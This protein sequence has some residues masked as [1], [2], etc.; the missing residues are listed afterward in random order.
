MWRRALGPQLSARVL[1]CT[2]GA[3]GHHCRT[4]QETAAVRFAEQAESAKI[5]RYEFELLKF[6]DG[7]PIPEGG[8]LD[9]PFLAALWKAIREF[10]PDYLFCPPLPT[11]PLMGVHTDHL[12]VA[13][14]VRRVAY[15]INVP[16][17]FSDIYPTDESHSE[18]V[19]TPVIFNVY[20]GYMFG[21]N[22]YDLAVDVEDA[23]PLIAACAYCHRSQF[24]EWIP[25]IGRHEI[26]G[27]T[28]IE[29]WSEALRRRM[30][31]QRQDMRV[32]G[33]R[34]LEFFTATAWGAAP[35]MEGLERDFPSLCRT[36]SR[37]GALGEKLSRW[38]VL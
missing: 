5:G 31:R 38:G 22:Q 4:R 6:P 13:E 14:A 12:T 33:D 28:T 35:T 37:L 24:Q 20:D 19:K 27:P 23:F 11:D 3:A 36:H 32:G 16:H 10:E 2:D 1:V 17:A 21:A 15:L 30:A 25:W 9:R 29:E 18:P 7:R 8:I 26:R 34:A